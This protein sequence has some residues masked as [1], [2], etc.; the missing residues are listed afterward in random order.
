MDL[1]DKVLIV[2]NHAENRKLLFNFLRSHNCAVFSITDP[3]AAL[4]EMSNNQY[5]MVFLRRKL[6]NGSFASVVTTIS[7]LLPQSPLVVI[8]TQPELQ[9][10]LTNK[11]S[12]EKIIDKLFFDTISHPIQE[13][14]INKLLQKVANYRKPDV[15]K[16]QNI[17]SDSSSR[18]WKLFTTSP[19]MKTMMD[20]VER[21]LKN[22]KPVLIQGEVG[23]GKELIA[24]YIHYNS[25]LTSKGPF[26]VVNLSATPSEYVGS[27]LWGNIRLAGK[28]S[29]STVMIKNFLNVDR[30]LLTNFVDS[31]Q[32]QMGDNNMPRLIF[33]IRNDPNESV[34]R[35]PSPPV[36][37]ETLTPLLINLPPLRERHGD[38]QTM[39]DYFLSHFAR[40]NHRPNL[41]FTTNARKLLSDYPWPGNVFELKHLMRILVE[42]ALEDTI[43]TSAVAPFVAYNQKS[44]QTDV[45]S[46]EEVIYNKLFHL[47]RQMDDQE[48]ISGLYTLIQPHFERPLIRLALEKT[49]H[50]QLK[51]AKLLGINRNTLSS[52]MKKLDLHGKRK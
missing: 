42:R 37:S 33:T 21:S 32:H 12:S 43:N 1:P 4:A 44:R 29:L 31:Y 45:Q 24:K 46:L 14:D 30:Q 18:N 25:Q 17:K 52:K 47:F 49:G 15:A 13:K 34:G 6:I 5:S 51:A 16:S 50:N 27:E 2:D 22:L 28:K 19:A 35:F 41:Q 3:Q 23:T 39:S 9:D 48:E 38:I 7:N 10:I 40:L 36:I 20:K 8:G 26:L 11:V